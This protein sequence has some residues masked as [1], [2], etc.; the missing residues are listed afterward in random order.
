MKVAVVVTDSH[1][2]FPY[3]IPSSFPSSIPPPTLSLTFLDFPS[4]SSI[5]YPPFPRG[6]YL[7]ARNREGVDLK[8]TVRLN[9]AGRPRDLKLRLV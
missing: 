1:S 8:S 4:P 3:L 9:E 6:A 7:K 2:P 5:L